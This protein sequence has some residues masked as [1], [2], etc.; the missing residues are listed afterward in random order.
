[1]YPI[2]KQFATSCITRT[3]AQ[4]LGHRI[5]NQGIPGSN[6]IADEKYIFLFIL[7][8]KMH[9]TFY[10]KQSHGEHVILALL[11]FSCV[12]SCNIRVFKHNHIDNMSKQKSN[13]FLSSK[14]KEIIFNF[15]R[16]QQR[17]RKKFIVFEIEINSSMK[18][19]YVNV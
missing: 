19:I 3:I 10:Q 7:L 1:M 11:H 5:C 12:L 9:I 14:A 4:W 15:R 16:Q 18:Y 17:Q 6:H 2:Y 8:N 13:H